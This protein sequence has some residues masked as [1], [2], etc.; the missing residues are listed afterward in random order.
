M[1]FTLSTGIAAMVTGRQFNF[2]GFIFNNMKRNLEDSKIKFLLYPRFLQMIINSEI[3]GLMP[4]GDACEFNHM[5]W[6]VLGNM[7][8]IHHKSIFD[9]TFTPLFPNML[10]FVHQEPV[11]Q[12]E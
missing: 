8:K 12:D 10:P 5:T 1:S 4:E 11:V 3:Q 7:K 9:G 2:S 6:K